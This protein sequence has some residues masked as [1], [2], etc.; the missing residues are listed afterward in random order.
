MSD[1]IRNRFRPSKATEGQKKSARISWKSD[2]LPK[3]NKTTTDKKPQE[4][5]KPDLFSIWD[6]QRKMDAEEKKMAQELAETKRKARE[7]QKTLRKHQFGEAKIK[8][9]TKSKVVATKSKS[10]FTKTK[11]WIVSNK[12]KTS[13]LALFLLVPIVMFTVFSG[14][15]ETPTDTLGESV[16]ISSQDLPREKPDFELLYPAGSDE[17]TLEVVRNSPQGSDPSYVYVDS[18]T[19]ADEKFQ[20]SQ[21][22]EPDNFDLEK[23]SKDF[24]A[25]NIIQIDDS[26]VYHGYSEKA[27]IQSLMFVKDGKLVLI[28]SPKKFPDDQWAN[29]IISMK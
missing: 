4:V 25:T 19:D 23:T 17:G 28:S 18:F 26:K 3:T 1:D 16:N 13:I 14:N 24:Q 8:L 2:N 10:H 22:R 27:G 7:L 12:K 11:S 20:V 6:D 9:G 21:Q 5:S 29:Y 15:N